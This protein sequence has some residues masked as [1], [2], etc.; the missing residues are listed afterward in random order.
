[1]SDSTLS[2]L[3]NVITIDDDRIQE[4]PQPGVPIRPRLRTSASPPKSV[5]SI[6]IA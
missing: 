3:S 1:M 6:D 2:P 5:G 4:P